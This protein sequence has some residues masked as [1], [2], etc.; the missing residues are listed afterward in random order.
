VPRP[1]VLITG[2][3]GFVGSHVADELVG[4]ADVVLVDHLGA[5][6]RENV[7]AAVAAGA[8]FVKRDLL[9]G[10][11]RPLFR[12]V[13]TV[14]HFAAN[15]DVRLGRGGAKAQVEQNV[16]MTSRV[17]E[18]CRA[19]RVPRIVFA[20]TSTVYGEAK[21]VPTPEDYA[22]L[23]PISLYGATKL[24]CESLL[25]AYAHSFGI[26]AVVFRLA[27]I[28][29][30]RSGHGVTVD[31]VRKLRRNPKRLEI[32]GA[33]PGTSKSYVHIVD[34]L[35]GF[36]AGIASARGPLDVYN[37][38]SHDAI[39]VRRIADLICEAA[40]AEGV[41]YAWTGGAGGGRGWAG[42]VRTMGLALGRLQ[43]TGWRPTMT[44]EEA[45][46]RAAR[47]LWSRGSQRTP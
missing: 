45:V 17:L 28:V 41:E 29:G 14:Y 47:E 5:G 2:A 30:G 22:P 39:S 13:D 42:D 35:A 19:N 12:R 11:L 6:K 16:L 34:V 27:N 43:A 31:L 36:R 37:L 20:S 33:D 40:G 10:D 15:P 4:E 1:R 46:R 38:G 26:H 3:A 32:L 18:A 7:D 24:A 21:V 23:E 44:S 9:R 25:S 8:K